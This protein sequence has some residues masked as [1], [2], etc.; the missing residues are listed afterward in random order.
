M[1]TTVTKMQHIVKVAEDE[2]L[3]LH[4]ETDADLV[5]LA[6][7]G[8]TA[9]NV[10][11]ALLELKQ[12]I[13]DITGGGVVTGVKGEAEEGYRQGNVNITKANVGLG[14][15]D[16]TAD[17]D[18]PVSTAQQAALNAKEDKANLKALA[19]KD[20]LSKADVGLGNVTN[21]AQVKRTEMG[22]ASGVATLDETGKV[23]AAQLPS[24]VDD[25]IEGTYVNQTTFNDAD[26]SPVTLET[27]KIYVDTTSN[28][29]YRWGGS[30]LVP[31]SESL[32]LGETSSTAYAGNKGKQNADNIATLQTRVG[33]I[34]AKNTQQD[35]AISA[36]QSAAEAA[37]DAADAAQTAA[38][39]ADGKAVAAQNKAN[40][41]ETNIGK[42]VDGTTKVGKAG[43]ADSATAAGKLATA[44]VISLTGD[45]TGSANFDGSVPTSIAVTLKNSGVAAGTYSAVQV[46]TKGRVTK[47]GQIYVLGEEGQETPP[48]DLAIGAFFI[49]RL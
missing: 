11:G 8:I 20:S 23:P 25:V 5:H 43:T 3:L 1:A 21:D 42:I 26:G 36:A 15:V 49:R 13:S 44:Q 27:G 9:D 30:Q 16:N 40:T 32:A 35:T 24:Y 39:T 46:D 6:A 48:D 7:E 29:E 12:L 28:K 45:A 33:D 38:E 17:A 18:K 47:G 37:Q 4:P 34:E 31:I 2:Y 14:N 19:Y 41:N 22:A 10:E